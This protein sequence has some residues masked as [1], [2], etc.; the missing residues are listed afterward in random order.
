M[1]APLSKP[2]VLGDIAPFCYGLAADKSF[3]S[4][5]AQAGRACVLILAETLA[6]PGLTDLGSALSDYAEILDAAGAD[7]VVVVKEPYESL[8][9]HPR[10]AF[11]RAIV[12]ACYA[13]G[14]FARFD[15]TP[16]KPMALIL[17]RSLR[18]VERLELTDPSDAAVAAAAAIAGLPAED[19]RDVVMPAPVLMIHNLIEKSLCRAL[20]ERFE[21]GG[22]FDSGMASMDA[23]GQPTYKLDYGKKRR[24]DHLLEPGEALHD[25]VMALLTERCG[26]EVKKAFQIDIAHI[27]RLLIARY[28]ADGGHFQRHRDN[29]AKGVLFRQFAMSLNLNEDEYDGGELHFPEYNSHRYSPPTGSGVIFSAS[30]LHEVSP[31]TRGSRYVLLTFLHD[32]AAE[33]RRLIEVGAG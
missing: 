22:N 11:G 14:F 20:I 1:N 28:D 7:I 2:L 24:R 30:L 9:Q 8:V 15:V 19:A 17:D 6:T 21:T 4:F 32:E 23:A 13:E 27:D 5:Q 10:T 25:Q 16:S 26:A 33:A 18:I 31:I 29:A 3:Y 12:I